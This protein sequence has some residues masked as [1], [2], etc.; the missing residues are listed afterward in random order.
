MVIVMNQEEFDRQFQELDNRH[1]ELSDK[2]LRRSA[3][4]V[5]LEMKRLAKSHK[6]LV[7]YIRSCFSLT[8]DSQDL[9]EHEI[10]IENALEI[11]AF[12]ESEEKA[13]KF[14]HDYDED[15]YQYTAYWV[16]AC[17]YDNLAVHTANR[18]GYNSQV[19]HGAVDDGMHVCRRTGKLECV[20]CFREYAI[21]INIAS[22]DYEMGEHYA[23]ICSVSTARENADCRHWAGWDYLVSISIRQGRLQEALDAMK[24]AFKTAKQYH[25]PLS[26]SLQSGM[27]LE[28]LLALLGKEDQWDALLAEND[29]QWN[30]ADFPPLEE[31]PQ[32]NILKTQVEAVKLVRQNRPLEA[33]E[34]LAKMER[35]VLGQG[36]VRYWFDLRCYRIAA[37]LF[38]GE[39]PEETLLGSLVEELRRRANKACQWSAIQ[40]VDA[41][42]D[43]SPDKPSVLNPAAIHCPID[44]GPYAS[45]KF[46]PGSALPVISKSDEKKTDVPETSASPKEER[47][48]S[49]R[50]LE[51]ERERV[52]LQQLWNEAD[53]AS[54]GDLPFEKQAELDERET[55]LYDKYTRFTPADMK[56]EAPEK[57]TE[58]ELWETGYSLIQMKIVNSAERI[59]SLWKWRDSFTEAFPDSPLLLANSAYIAFVLRYEAEEKEIDPDS[60]GIPSLEELESRA[61]RAFEKEPTRSGIATVAGM[62]CEANGHSREAQRYFSRACQIHRLNEYAAYRLAVLYNVAERPR[63]ALAVVDLYLRAGGRDQAVLWIGTQIAFKSQLFDQFLLYEATYSESSPHF[64]LDAQKS[65]AFFLSEKYEES[66]AALSAYEEKWNKTDKSQELFKVLLAAVLKEGDWKTRLLAALDFPIR[67]DDDFLFGWNVNLFTLIWNLFDESDRECPVRAKYVDFLFTHGEVPDEYFQEGI[68]ELQQD[69]EDEEDFDDDEE[70]EEFVPIPCWKCVLTQ[71]LDADVPTWAGWNRIPCDVTDY[72]VSWFVYHPQQEETVRRVLAEQSRCYPLAP[73]VF[74]VIPLGEYSV[75]CPHIIGMGPREQKDS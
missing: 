46:Q 28:L 33:A 51:I 4:Q 63:D 24:M 66:R 5:A 50:T 55:R 14:Q 70:E 39:K 38:A 36:N 71:P 34:K 54:A 23:R 56:S 22:G 26:A 10:G 44:A 19:V 48:K 65:I 69:E 67:E 32:L 9:L 16:S 68:P 25:D 1:S 59:R 61:V 12:V 74:E 53:Q 29:V 35:F 58:D 21:E 41:M 73:E 15:Y 60:L 45:P 62:L 72:S 18:E 57:L 17:A 13:K 31:S 27:R 6:Q 40:Q 3:F 49:E 42:L 20:E 11:I 43:P 75:P 7:P 52:E 30:P 64:L 37:L 47:P 8:N 2:Q